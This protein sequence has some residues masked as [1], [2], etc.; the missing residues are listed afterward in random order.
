MQKNPI[1]T[2]PIGEMA[3]L[4]LHYLSNPSKQNFFKKKT[5]KES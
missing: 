5:N 4:S 2:R 3:I 1:S